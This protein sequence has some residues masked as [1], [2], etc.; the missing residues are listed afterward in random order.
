MKSNVSLSIRPRIDRVNGVVH[1]FQRLFLCEYALHIPLAF[2][3][4]CW[5]IPFYQNQKQLYHR[6]IHS[7][8]VQ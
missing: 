7:R 3:S 1:Q 6:D 2:L 4:L 8:Y 5:R